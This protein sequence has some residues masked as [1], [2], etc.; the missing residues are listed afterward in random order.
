MTG[1]FFLLVFLCGN[2]CVFGDEPPCNRFSFAEQLLE[3]VV[4][5]EFT[6]EKTRE[7]FFNEMERVEK[8]LKAEKADTMKL[9]H[10]VKQELNRVA[11]TK[12]ASLSSELTKVNDEISS[13]ADSKV[14]FNCHC[15]Y[16]G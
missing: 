7:K 13:F 6:V 2:A 1:L 4:R 9:V 10:E 12:F 5:L 3:K 8:K 14:F 15:F 16:D 11:D